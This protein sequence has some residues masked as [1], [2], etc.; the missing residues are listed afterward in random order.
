MTGVLL[1]FSG[2]VVDLVHRVDHLP[3]TGEEVE[4]PDVLIT[5]GGGFN[6]MIAAR[7]FDVPVRYAGTVGTGLFAD[8]VRTMLDEANIPSII[9]RAP[10]QDQGTCIVVVDRSGERS[11]ISYHG[12]ERQLEIADYATVIPGNDDWVLLTGYALYKVESAR[13]LS[14]WLDQLERGPTFLFDPGPTVA[15]IPPDRLRSAMLRA[16][17][18]S[19]NRAEAKVLTGETDPVL[20]ARNLGK[21]RAGAIVRSGAEGCWIATPQIDG[22][23]IPAFAVDS[24]DTNGAGDC[25]D[26]A[27]IAAMILGYPSE[28]AALLANAAAA[29][30]TTHRGPATAP[31]LAEVMS[32]IESRGLNFAGEPVKLKAIIRRN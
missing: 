20:A 23:F 6:A 24:V 9:S 31:K 21:G 30:S 11:F 2:V 3:V 19:A 17:W 13:V 7:N 5:A 16:D 4:T 1:Q 28:Q 22:A 29:L 10:K 27:F 12:A 15:D 8:M 14:R 25:H 18:V 32:F 26:G